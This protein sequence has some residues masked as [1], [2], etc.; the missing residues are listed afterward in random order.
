M[1]GE[2]RGGHGE[3]VCPADSLLNVPKT[4]FGGFCLDNHE[5]GVVLV[6]NLVTLIPLIFEGENSKGEGF[7][8]SQ[9]GSC[10]ESNFLVPVGTLDLGSL[11]LRGRSCLR[12]LAWTQTGVPSLRRLLGRPLTS[13]RSSE[14]R[15]PP[16][17]ADTPLT[18][19]VARML[20]TGP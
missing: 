9:S 18:G 8:I 2:G 20:K 1:G 19:E 5:T 7:G 17:S 13:P 3:V 6:A 4:V 15:P 12:G 16:G 10:R 11:F 14:P